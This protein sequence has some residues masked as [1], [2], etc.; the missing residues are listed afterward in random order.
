ME[1]GCPRGRWARG[2][3]GMAPP[4]GDRGLVAESGL[5]ASGERGREGDGGGEPRRSATALCNV[6]AGA[7][8]QCALAHASVRSA[9]TQIASPRGCR[10]RAGLASGAAASAAQSRP[11]A[12]SLAGASA[13][14]PGTRRGERRGRAPVVGA[15]LTGPPKP[16][17]APSPLWA[18]CS[19]RIHLNGFST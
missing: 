1:M 4:G 7:L 14:P 2:R 8:R 17:P 13:R 16:S 6:Q 3:P 5:D 19:Q 15:S 9:A 11:C 12:P 18:C 10:R